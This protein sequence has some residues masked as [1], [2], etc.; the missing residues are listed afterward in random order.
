MVDESNPGRVESCHGSTS[1]EEIRKQTPVRKLRGE[2]CW[3]HLRV[4]KAKFAE[5]AENGYMQLY[6]VDK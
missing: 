6:V 5:K 3:R 2:R 1:A 4:G